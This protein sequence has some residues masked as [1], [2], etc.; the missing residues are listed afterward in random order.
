MYNW[1]SGKRELLF[2]N[3]RLVAE[4]LQMTGLLMGVGSFEPQWLVVSAW[5]VC[6]ADGMSVLVDRAH[7]WDC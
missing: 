6:P 3:L 7:G 5:F 4:L 2:A 1:M